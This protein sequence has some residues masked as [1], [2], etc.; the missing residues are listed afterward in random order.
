MVSE[1]RGEVGKEGNVLVVQRIHV[2]YHL[3]LDFEKL[4]EAQRA[5]EIHASNCPAARTIRDCVEI[6]TSLIVESL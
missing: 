3:R 1:A 2:D 4:D 5:H 6:T